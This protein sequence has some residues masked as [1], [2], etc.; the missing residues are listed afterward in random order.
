MVYSGDLDH[1]DE[2][3]GTLLTCISMYLSVTITHLR[4]GSQSFSRSLQTCTLNVVGLP[5][6]DFSNKR[7]N[8]YYQDYQEYMCCMVGT[9]TLF[10]IT[11]NCIEVEMKHRALC[12][13]IRHYICSRPSQIWSYNKRLRL[14]QNNHWLIWLSE[15]F[16]IYHTFM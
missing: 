14:F 4:V 5:L 6:K 7:V 10:K 9:L 2:A 13:Y 15:I 11:P 1:L 8:T 16:V 3:R 12:W